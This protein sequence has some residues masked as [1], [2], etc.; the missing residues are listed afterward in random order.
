[1]FD[2]II[3]YISSKKLKGFI[4]DNKRYKSVFD[5]MNNVCG[6]KMWNFVLD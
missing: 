2:I 4:F 6:K 3:L 5:S 1:M